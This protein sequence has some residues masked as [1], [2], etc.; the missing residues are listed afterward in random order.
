MRRRFYGGRGEALET[1]TDCLQTSE[2]VRIAT[3]YF[4]ASGFQQLQEVLLN[5]ELRLLV[6]R[7]QGARD[8]LEDVIKEFADSLSM[9]DL[10]GR[11]TTL[12]QMLD[13]LDK[14]LLTVGVGD[15]PMDV[16][17]AVEGK[18]LYQHAKLYIADEVSCVV[19]SANMSFHGLVRSRESGILTDEIEDVSYFVNR[20]DG[21]FQKAK[22]V[23]DKFIEQLRALLK[24]HD[25]FAIYARALL[26]LYKLPE[27][28]VPPQLLSL[29]TY[30]KPAVTRVKN[31]IEEHGGSFFV[32]STGL[33]KT[34][35]ASHVAAYLKM[36][37][38]IDRVIVICPAGLRENWRRFMRSSRL[39]SEEFSYNTLSTEDYRTNRH[40]IILER[41]L[42][43]ADEKTFVIVDESH[44]LRTDS[45]FE[46]ERNS[47]VRSIVREKN[48]KLLMLTATPFS[49]DISDVNTQLA[50]IPSPKTSQQ[51]SLGMD[52]KQDNWKVE[53]SFELSELSPAFVLTTPS[54]V[55]HFSKQDEY[56]EKYIEF[57]EE[58]R[59]YFPRKLQIRSIYFKNMMDDF[60]LGLLE[61]RLLYS[62]IKSKIDD[63]QMSFWVDEE[64]DTGDGKRNP[65][66]ESQIV[67]QFCSS[68]AKV[69]D[70]C[71]KVMGGYSNMQFAQQAELETYIQQHENLLDTWRMGQEDTKL[72][73]LVKL[74]HQHS[75]EKLVIFCIYI[76]TAK[77]LKQ[78]L[79]ENFE[80][81]SIET[82]AEQKPE[83]VDR[84]LQRFAPIS[85]EVPDDLRDKEIDILIATKAISE[86]YNLQDA[87]ILINY[88]LP[89]TVLQLAQRLGRI[90]RPWH[91]PRSIIVYNF[92]PST[93]EDGYYMA[94]NWGR[95]LVEYSSEYRSF[96]EIPILLRDKNT[97]YEM[98]NL[99]RG[100]GFQDN[101]DLTLDEVLA[102]VENAEQLQ[103]THFYDDLALIPE[104]F[105]NEVKS[106]P[107]GIRSA[108]YKKGRRKKLFL[109]I[110]L[111][112]KYFP[113]V[114]DVNGKSI[115]G[116]EDPDEIMK[117]IR[118]EKHTER[119]SFKDYPTDAEY[120][121]WIEMSKQNWIA[122]RKLK[123]KASQIQITC[124]LALIPATS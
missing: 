96:A 83:S 30:Q 85:N 119:V 58:D 92:I 93:M 99:A 77:Y 14:G 56:G 105:A 9:G 53:Q 15:D 44:H 43:D 70:F 72:I 95:R 27:E 86:G 68:P 90:L 25:P 23:T 69:D 75:D 100:L 22:S 97:D 35:M 52:V 121:D 34:V 38:M 115:V 112:N 71:V 1:I 111:N 46:S 45:K 32:A 51:T 122:Q 54:V 37:D 40:V 65:L 76:E 11:T 8:R 6:G 21:F 59:R 62:E 103:T 20:F 123:D 3:A 110:K 117:L 2:L 10:T 74:V 63:S 108:M 47:R 82:T 49:K 31:N 39:S 57:S 16:T 98:V 109:L 36:I 124:A 18:Y 79:K 102:F 118:C 33:G 84:I 78:M 24:S 7:E 55:K 61:D 106:F 12:R 80:Q 89:W 26:E 64:F 4:E 87:A 101:V 50:L 28:Q 60:L 42:Q 41:E 88:D 107:H 114:F 116:S 94:R 66:F 19:T 48:A 113:S 104:D 120:D 17:S 73:E 29:A 5:R 13:A 67:H 91:E 81:L